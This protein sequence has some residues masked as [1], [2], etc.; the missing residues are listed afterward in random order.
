MIKYIVIKTYS[1]SI[2]IHDKSRVCNSLEEAKREL[3]RLY[4]EEIVRQNKLSE[5]S[6]YRYDID[7]QLKVC[8]ESWAQVKAY[9][10][11]EDDTLI[12]E[13]KTNFRIIEIEI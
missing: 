11:S 13:D 9:K 4:A 3:N 8:D 6:T 2:M 1:W 10:Y 12:S 5:H 7:S